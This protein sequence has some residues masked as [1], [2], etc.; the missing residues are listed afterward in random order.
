MNTRR[1]Y[2]FDR[3]GPQQVGGTYFNYYWK[4]SYVV[5]AIVWN[6]DSWMIHV[7]W[8]DGQRSRHCT[9][10]DHKKDRVLAQPVGTV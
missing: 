1:S 2:A 7:T 5:D 3:L 6:N 4:Q 9:A 10:W 8:E